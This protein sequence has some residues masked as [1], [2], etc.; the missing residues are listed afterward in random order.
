MIQVIGSLISPYVKKVV[1]L[2]NMKGVEF[3]VDPIT[4][5]YGD[6]RFTKLSPLRRIPVLIDGEIVLNDSSVIAQYIEETWPNP[7]ALPDTPADRARA[8]WIEEYSD[9]RIGDVFIWKGFVP[10]V[11]APYVF[12]GEPKTEAFKQNVDT[13]VVE[14]MDFLESEITDD[15]FLAGAFGLA[16]ISVASMFRNMR[17]AKWRPDPA[18][19]PKTCAWLERA[20]AE[21]CL[22]L[23]NEWSDRLLTTPRSERR[24]AARDMGLALTP[25]TLA[26]KTPRRGPVTPFEWDAS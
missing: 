3:E 23:A 11:V 24:Q 1:T 8:R 15:G 7:T 17:Y 2:L 10:I 13:E 20:E 6:E 4:P 22:A 14:V 18:R 16:D 12:G 26:T 5:F 19:W 21:P 25:E 9:T